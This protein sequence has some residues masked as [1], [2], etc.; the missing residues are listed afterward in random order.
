MPT[1]RAD[2]QYCQDTLTQALGFVLSLVW[3]DRVEVAF[4]TEKEAFNL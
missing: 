3:G 1:L 4:S 2:F